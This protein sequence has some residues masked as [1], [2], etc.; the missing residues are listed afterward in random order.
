MTCED[1]K[2]GKSVELLQIRCNIVIITS[3]TTEI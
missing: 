3:H 2:N 1:D